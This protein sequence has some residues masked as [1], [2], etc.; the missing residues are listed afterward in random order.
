MSFSQQPPE[1]IPE[2]THLL[3]A[4][5]P[6]LLE[7]F[8]HWFGRSVDLLETKDISFLSAEQLQDLLSRV[9][10]AQMQVRAS[11]SLAAATDSK[12]G[13]EM[14]VVMVWHKLVH[15]CWGVALR[16]RKEQAM[17]EPPTP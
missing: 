5:L 12:A 9:R 2:D 17:L 15:E 8:Q 7:D 6:P 1:D 10:S 13:I 3:K 16:Y 11:Q 4:V 14:S